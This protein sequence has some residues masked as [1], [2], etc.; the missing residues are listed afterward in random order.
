MTPAEPLHHSLAEGARAVTRI[1]RPHGSNHG[2]AAKRRWRQGMPPAVRACTP[3]VTSSDATGDA[4]PSCRN[5]LHRC[6]ALGGHSR[7][8]KPC[9]SFG[10]QHRHLPRI[11]GC[12][13]NRTPEDPRRPYHQVT[14][15]DAAQTGSGQQAAGSRQRAA[16]R[17]RCR[18]PLN[19]AIALRCSARPRTSE[20]WLRRRHRS[21]PRPGQGQT[22][23]AQGGFRNWT[24]RR[25]RAR[26]QR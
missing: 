26:R 2:T 6:L 23:C 22:S 9:A 25:P 19:L 16:A 20:H 14:L 4:K 11:S 12:G 8:G 15:A 18:R 10:S 21:R 1:S 24:C 7:Q 17:V 3:A 13:Q 5:P